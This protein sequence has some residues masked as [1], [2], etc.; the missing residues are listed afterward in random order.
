MRENVGNLRDS[1]NTAVP[2]FAPSYRDYPLPN[3]PPLRGRGGMAVAFVSSA[4]SPDCPAPLAR[5]GDLMLRKNGRGLSPGRRGMPVR[6]A[7]RTS[8]GVAATARAVRSV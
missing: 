8:T 3:P 1:L 6:S 5:Q 7:Q 4:H 2:A